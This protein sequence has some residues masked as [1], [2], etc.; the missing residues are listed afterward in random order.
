MKI[1]ITCDAKSSTVATIARILEEMGHQLTL[2]EGTVPLVQRLAQGERWDFVL[3]LSRGGVR[4][5]GQT[6]IPTVLEAF[7]IPYSFTEPLPAALATDT[8]SFCS[9]VGDMGL[10]VCSS[11]WRA[12]RTYTVA[13]IGTGAEASV[14]AMQED[15]SPSSGGTEYDVR[16]RALAEHAWRCL[17]L[18]DAGSIR[19]GVD[20]TGI[21]YLQGVD[22]VVTFCPQ[23]CDWTRVAIA[24]G[25][26]QTDL[27]RLVVDRSFARCGLQSAQ[28]ETLETRTSATVLRPTL[29]TGL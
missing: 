9:V 21:P 5:D 6:Q 27:V 3:N 13:M 19:I 16:V 23:T 25:R 10:P 17:S 18:R 4:K 12:D 20:S 1:A 7:R 28:V 15:N 24:S 11:S 2:V 8:K 29:S 14:L 22:P 26:T